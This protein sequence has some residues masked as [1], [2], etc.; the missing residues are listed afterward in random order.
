MKYC[1]KDFEDEADS[2]SGSF[3]YEG[4]DDKEWRVFTDMEGGRYV[5]KHPLRYCPFCG[6][7]L[8]DA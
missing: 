6:V 4:E 2:F 8:A 5:L 1:C 3:V 7:K